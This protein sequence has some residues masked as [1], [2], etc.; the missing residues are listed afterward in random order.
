VDATERDWQYR[1]LPKR[2]RP[3]VF[4]AKR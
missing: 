1:H 3:V 2:L 4:P